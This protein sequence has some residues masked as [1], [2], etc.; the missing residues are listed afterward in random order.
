MA[1]IIFIIFGVCVISLITALSEI[2]FSKEGDKSKLHILFKKETGNFILKR[3][4]KVI[5]KK[6]IYFLNKSI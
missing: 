5:V 6:I 3:I 4:V 1:E 2:S